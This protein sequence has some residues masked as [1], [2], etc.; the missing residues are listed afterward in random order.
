VFGNDTSSSGGFGGFFLSSNGV[1]LSGVTAANNEAGV[2]GYDQS[3]TGGL[4]GYFSSQNG[5]GI[6]ASAGGA[7]PAISAQAGASE[8]LGGDGIDATAGTGQ[9]ADGGNGIAATG[10]NGGA[11]VF[12]SSVLAAGSG[13]VGNGGQGS[14]ANAWSVGGNA[15]AGVTGTG[16]GG[17]GL[18]ASGFGVEGIGG[19]GT[20][21][22]AGGGGIYG[23]AGSDG[24]A[25]PGS[26]GDFQGDVLVEGTRNVSGTISA[27]VKDF[28]VDDPRD[29]A[30]KYLVHTSVESPD[31][32]DVYNGNATTDAGGYATVVLPAYFDAE[33]I[34]PRYQLTV[35]GAFAQAV[36]WRQES[37]NQF[38]IRTN[39]GN[40]KVSWQVTGIRNDPYARS[41]RAPA[42]QAKP[43]AD[44]GKYLYPAGYG[45]A[46]S[47]A[48]GQVPSPTGVTPRRSPRPRPPAPPRQLALGQAPAA[49]VSP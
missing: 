25:G 44:R 16:G 11:C 15:G 37:H 13:V 22:S 23:Q 4:A 20:A 41:V 35:I 17:G 8:F 32:E 43:A 30:H 48:I 39:H 2:S 3:A 14:P 38:T 36:V 33:N 7:N 24:D 9:N 6:S 1:G 45:Q 19:P 5:T 40:V 27:G 47:A 28:K 18:G 26:A 12:C 49:P 31:A 42:E 29:P 46:A 34:D 10:G 21:H